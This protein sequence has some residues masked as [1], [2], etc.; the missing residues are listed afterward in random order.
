MMKN[1]SEPSLTECEKSDRGISRRLWIH[2][3]ALTTVGIS[4]IARP[5]PLK[6]SQPAVPLTDVVRAM[7]VVTGQPVAEKWVNPT[8]SLLGVI[9]NSTKSL[10]ELELGEIEPKHSCLDR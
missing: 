6:A 9:L 3:M 4:T 2:G 8:A 10:R 7:A 1:S 5:S